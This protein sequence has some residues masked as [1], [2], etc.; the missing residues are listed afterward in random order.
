MNKASSFQDDIESYINCPESNVKIVKIVPLPHARSEVWAY[1]GFIA[2]D[3]GEI[4][5]KKKTVCRIC[6]TTLC[7]SG[8]TTNLFTH[9]KAMHP[10]VNPQKLAPTNKVP[11]TGKKSNRRKF[12]DDNDNNLIPIEIDSQSHFIV[13]NVS[14][15]QSPDLDQTDQSIITSNSITSSTQLINT[16]SNQSELLKEKQQQNSTAYSIINDNQ[17]DQQD[18]TTIDELINKDELITD[19]VVNLIVRDCRPIELVT[20][21]YFDELIK[22]LAPNYK[23]PQIDKLEQLVKKKYIEVR[24][25]LILRSMDD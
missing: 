15:N 3:N 13:R 18:Q 25:D 1:F 2:D 21:K 20:G 19:A 10:E 12:F 11:R 23:L 24:R 7:Y 16:T 9:L 22:L 5:D 8:N 4:H 6:A 17:M 14:I